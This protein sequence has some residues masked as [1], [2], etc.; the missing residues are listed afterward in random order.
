M[1]TASIK[2][3]A[4]LGTA[5]ML[6]SLPA[7][8]QEQQIN[9][10]GSS[11]SSGYYPYYTAVANSISS[12]WD[13]LNVTVVSPGGFAAGQVLLL[14]GEVDFAGQSPELINQA[15][16]QGRDDIRVLWWAN[17]AVQNVMAT[18]DSGI[19]TVSDLNGACFHPGMNGS[20]TQRV[21][22]QILEILEIEPDELLLTDAGGAVEAIRNGRCEA[23]VKSMG[24]E[25]LDGATAELN[26][27]TSLQPVTY[28]E[29]QRDLIRQEIPW[30]TF[31]EVPE[32]IVEGAPSYHMP[33]I[34]VG[35]AATADMDEETA[36]Q[37][38]RGMW[39]GIDQQRAAFPAMEGRDV[40]AQ[41]IDV[42]MTLHAGAVR[43]YGELGYDVPDAIVPPEMN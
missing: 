1:L 20:S 2:T 6:G 18:E 30:M 15:I 40:P 10:A 38:V 36:Y 37:I 3:A 12:R 34:W 32:G 31:Y 13:D 21:M 29:E 42:G 35:F 33:S 25:T 8:A 16:E 5:L 23:Q 26:V 7:I 43:Y 14:D 24:G 39:E 4:C 41:T 28:T 22:L 11:T 17:P 19:E 27:T 9:M